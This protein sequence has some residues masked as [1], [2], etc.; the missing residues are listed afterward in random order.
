MSRVNDIP[1]P[2]Q[3]V[4]WLGRAGT[5]AG[6][7]ASKRCTIPVLK[8]LAERLGLDVDTRAKRP[9]LIDQIVREA[10]KR[11]D[12]S[13]NEMFDMSRDELLMY[14]EDV[15]VEADE[16]LEI[17]KELNLEPTKEA[18]RNL[19]EFTAREISE[20]GRFQRIAAKSSNGR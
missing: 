5:R 3:L 1:D 14:F 12:K 7:S 17:L 16:L 18:Q 11:V 4:D 9:D 13:L 6:L 20:T 2:R 8:E 19:L 10:G 15:G